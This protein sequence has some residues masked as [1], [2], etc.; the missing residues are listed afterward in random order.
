MKRNEIENLNTLLSTEVKTYAFTKL[1]GVLNRIKAYRNVYQVL[2][3]EEEYHKIINLTQI[4]YLDIDFYKMEKLF[5]VIEVLESYKVKINSNVLTDGLNEF[6]IY[7]SEL[8]WELDIDI[9]DKRK[10]E[11]SLIEI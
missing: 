11:K 5:S 7:L 6:T 10:L 1:A 2:G 8:I 9:K 4:P 3:I